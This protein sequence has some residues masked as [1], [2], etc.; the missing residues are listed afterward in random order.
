MGVANKLWWAVWLFSIFLYSL[1][2]NDNLI[3]KLM[4][5]QE[6]VLYKAYEY[7]VLKKFISSP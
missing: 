5:P 6:C 4:E 2:N 7:V 1:G 3:G